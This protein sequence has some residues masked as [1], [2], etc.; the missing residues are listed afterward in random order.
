MIA[1]TRQHIGLL[2]LAVM[3]SE[4]RDVESVLS[5]FKRCLNT[6]ELWAESYVSFSALD[7]DQ[8]FKVGSELARVVLRSAAAA[9]AAAPT[10]ATRFYSQIRVASFGPAAQPSAGQ[11]CSPQ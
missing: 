9:A 1:A 8:V 11:A 10:R 6:Y 3:D 4:T 5:D 7:V 2:V